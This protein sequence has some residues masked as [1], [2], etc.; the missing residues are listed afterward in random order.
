MASFTVRQGITFHDG[1]K[2]RAQDVAHPLTTAA[3]A[4]PTAETLTTLDANGD[5]DPEPALAE[6]WRQT[7][8][9]TGKQARPISLNRWMTSRTVSSSACASWAI[10]AFGSDVTP[11]P[12]ATAQ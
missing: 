6:K 7:G 2:V 3:N 10:T 8:A 1:T 5:P 9:S 12:T 4:T 11:H